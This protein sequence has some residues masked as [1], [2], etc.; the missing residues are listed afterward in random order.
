[1]QISAQRE[2]KIWKGG[3]KTGHRSNLWW[4][5][6]LK[7]HRLLSSHMPHKQSF[8]LALLLTFCCQ[9]GT[10]TNPKPGGR[11]PRFWPARRS[12]WGWFHRNC[13]C[14]RRRR[15]QAG[16]C[17]S[18]PRW[19]EY[20]PLGRC[21]DNRLQWPRLCLLWPNRFE[22]SWW[23]GHFRHPRCRRWISGLWSHQ[24]RCMRNPTNQS[25]HCCPQRGISS[26]WNLFGRVPG[27][28]R[29]GRCWCIQ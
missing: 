28:T 7:G 21:T 1:M 26:S 18:I 14:N 17:D 20:G 13:V 9:W 10:R 2:T 19:L 16:K 4:W 3:S 27:H 23:L 8:I 22:R 5:R 24:E 12:K 25:W 29:V 6:H 11:W 15:Y